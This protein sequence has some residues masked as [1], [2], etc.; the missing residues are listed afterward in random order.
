MEQQRQ[1]ALIVLADDDMELVSIL[2]KS[3][4]KKGYRVQVAYDGREAMALIYEVRPDLVVLDV[5]MPVMNG[6]EVC[7]EIRDDPQ[8]RSTGVIM[9]TGI[10]PNLNE[11][12][13]P[14]YGA[15]DYL[16]KP[17][18]LNDLHERIEALLSRSTL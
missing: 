7:K 12:T 1:G 15:D 13:S 14:L 11:M 8:I 16:D 2:Q 3:L 17:V 6:W 4:E 5:M 9:L 10:G 18:D